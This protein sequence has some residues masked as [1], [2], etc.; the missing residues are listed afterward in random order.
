MEI[1]V[2]ISGAT[3]HIGQGVLIECLEHPGV[4]SIPVIG[5]NSCRVE[6]EKVTEIIHSDFPDFS[7]L[8]NRDIIRLARKERE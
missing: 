3:G 2:I 7:S 5:R 8:E 6:H 4:K 1:K